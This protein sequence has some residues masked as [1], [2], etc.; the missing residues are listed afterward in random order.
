MPQ[1]RDLLTR[2]RDSLQ[3]ALD[4]YSR[5]A[6]VGDVAAIIR[7]TQQRLERVTRRLEGLP[8]A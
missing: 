2:A 1:E 8:W 4:H 5:V 3:S 7:G 6:N